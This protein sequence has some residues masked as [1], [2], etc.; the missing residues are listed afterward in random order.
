MKTITE[1]HYQ[2][3]FVK[4]PGILT[5]PTPPP[6]TPAIL[7]PVHFFLLSFPHYSFTLM[8]SLG[9]SS[10][11][12]TVRGK[13]FCWPLISGFEAGGDATTLVRACVM[14]YGWGGSVGGGGV[15]RAHRL[16]TPATRKT[17]TVA[18]KRNIK[19]TRRGSP[20]CHCRGTCAR[21]LQY[22]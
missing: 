8:I 13:L 10:P 20:S 22:V 19:C 21:A 2:M 11:H 7:V 9:G 1:G 5:T 16:D 12:G 17:K 6:P 14:V 4:L 3:R 18:L 15:K